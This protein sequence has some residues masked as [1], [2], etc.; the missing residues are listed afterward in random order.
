MTTPGPRATQAEPLIW[1]NV[2]KR[3]KNFTGRIGILDR[4]QGEDGEPGN[5]VT[6]VL[7]EDHQPHAL[8]GLGGVGKTA[9][10]IE[11]AWRYRHKYDI[12]W[13]VPSDQLALIR[14][15]LA[16]LAMRLG[17]EAATATGIDAAANLAL[18]AL[19]R[20]EPYRRWLLIFDNADQPEDIE[21]FIPE[22]PGDVLITSRNHRWLSRVDTVQVDVFS[23][24]ESTEFLTK[25]AAK[26]LTEASA[27]RLAEKLG[28][29]PLALEQAGALLSETGMA[30]DRYLSLLEGHVSEI[31]G[32]GKPVEYPLSMTA[33]WR[34]SVSALR[35]QLPQALELLR[36]CAYFSPDPIP[37]DI[38][39]NTQVTGT[40]VSDLIA[41][42]ILL[43]QV[44]GTLGRFALVKVDGRMISVHRLIQALL[45][46]EL[47][48]TQQSDYRHDVHTILAAGSPGSPTDTSRWP[49]YRQLLA[50]VMSD[51]TELA[52]CQ[53]KPVRVFAMEAVRYLYLSG[54][55]V[56]C[57]LLAEKFIAQWSKE[58]GPDNAFVLDA[59]RHRGN[60]LRQ[61]GM[62][63]EAYDIIES[64][65]AGATEVLGDRDPL[66]L[67]LRNSFGADLRARGKFQD[68]LALDRDTHELHV[69]EFGENDAQTLRVANNLASDYGLN[70]RYGEARKLH[71]QV[72]LQQ[73]N[74]RSGV[75]A[76][77]VL[78]SWSG[79]AWAIRLSGDFLQARDVGEAAW[80]F[81]RVEL[82]PEHYVTLRTA[83][84]LSIALR[85][86]PST[87]EEALEIA[88]TVYS[89]CR[90]L[91]GDLNP[92]T[93]A[94]AISLTNIQRTIGQTHEALDLA[95]R[96]VERYP[97]VFGPDHP[98]NHGCAGNLALLLRVKGE[99]ARARIVNEAALAALDARLTRD[100]DFSLVVAVNL[101]SDYAALGNVA[102]AR[103]LGQDSLSRLRRLMGERHPQTL[104]CAA[105][106]VVDL[107]ADGA[108]EEA[109]RLLTGTLDHY[110]NTLGS[111]H[112]DA[113]NAASGLRLDID[114]DPPPI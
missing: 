26:A 111:D 7:P 41:D 89:L 82:G 103:E 65:L 9:V 20:G 21:K 40:K 67:A 4:L 69:Q 63:S 44:I 39:D 2:P 17:L 28:D 79:L 70:A 36:C 1:G 101:A 37:Q 13:W 113:V 72:Y 18:D 110:A 102:A 56:S 78:S 99:P 52:Q 51:T 31:L 19:R 90:Q 45:R 81:G 32:Q 57:R 93:M 106:L 97:N 50:H 114:F 86:I 98:Y 71:T 43:S 38:F 60:A 74:A 58:S 42:P 11:Y 8:Q 76:S 5:K 61:L 95:E 14:P 83:T 100:H 35:D 68:A 3:I 62:Y 92:D 87:H 33:A 96:T 64:T 66:T 109:E 24:S 105:N 48:D 107:R 75:S 55:L 53:D 80:D 73:R 104:G 94:A 25:R 27:D 16:Q 59:K 15:E 91:K 6:A 108:A 29:L 54:D 23:R 12:V 30:V 88:Q 112:P 34:L 46:D 77:E 49:R 47:D 10:A 22:G 85:R 84:G